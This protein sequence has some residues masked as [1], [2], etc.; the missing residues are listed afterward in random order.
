[1]GQA[2]VLEEDLGKGIIAWTLN[3]AGG[4]KLRVLNYG[5]TVQKLILP[6]GTDVVIG[7]DDVAGYVENPYFAQLIG[8]YGNRIANGGFTLDG[9]QYKLAQN[10]G[11]NNLH[12]GIQAFHTKLWRGKAAVAGNCAV[13]RLALHSP[14]GE[15]GFPGNLDAEVTYTITADNVWRVD[16]SAQSDAATPVNLTQHAYFNLKGDGQGDM[17]DHDLQLFADSYLPVDETLIP[18]GERRAV[19]GTPF[20]FTSPKKIGKEIETD[21]LQLRY[22]AGYDHTWILN[23]PDGVL[24]RAARLAAAGRTLEVWTTEPGV[25][26]Y[27]GN[28]IPD[29]MKGKHTY[30]RRGGIA[31]ETQH[32]PDSPNHPDFPSTILRPGQTYQTTTEFRFS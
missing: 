6:D 26:V 18:T 4:L 3:G 1:M 25:Q 5:G 12:G 19:K 14:D 13:L 30:V 15:E 32:W 7:F 31:L 10:N 24:T 23:H 17:L 27:T 11:P 9:V 28:Y 20:D 2:S 16:Y 21:D 22:G 29:G 8:R